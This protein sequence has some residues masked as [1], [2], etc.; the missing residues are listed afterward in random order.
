[1]D[2]ETTQAIAELDSRIDR[3]HAEM[4]GEFA[5]VRS[6]MKTEFAAVRS[7]M[8]TEFAAVR[9]EMKAEFAAVRAELTG[10]I[11][12]VRVDVASLRE[13]VD[14]NWT[15]TKVLFETLRGDVH[16]LAGHVADLTSRL[17]PRYQ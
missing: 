9:S 2:V 15:R 8:K 5:A 12:A 7:E 14:T 3:L 16:M 17:P 11:G 10:E 1:M 13:T 4:K 6:E